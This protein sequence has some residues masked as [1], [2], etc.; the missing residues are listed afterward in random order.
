MATQTNRREFFR[1]IATADTAETR[2]PTTS[3]RNSSLT[4]QQETS[5][6]LAQATLG[7]NLD[8]I[9]TV[10]S[11]GIEAWIDNQFTVPQSEFLNYVNTQ[12]GYDPTS[13]D[14]APAWHF[15]YALGQMMIYGQ[16]LLRQRVALALSEIIVISSESSSI[17]STGNGMAMWFD[18]LLR[19]AFG[20]YRDLLLD[21]TLSPMMGN[22]LS[23]A[24]N[25][26][27][28][29]A[30]NR[31][32]DENYAREL[33]QLFTIGLFLLNDDGSLQLDGN[34]DPI[35]TYDNSDIT[36]FA[37]IFTG[38]D[39]DH[40]GDPRVTWTM[41]FGGGWLNT[42]TAVRPLKYYEDEHESGPKKLLNGTVVADGQ[43]ILQDVNAA[44]DNLFEHQNIAPFISRRLIQS[45]VKS[46]P[47]ADYISRISAVFNNNGA[48]VKG[49][50]QAVIKAILLDDEAR[51]LSFINTTSN[52][53]LREPF[54][55]FTQLMRAFN[56][57]NSET[58]FWDAGWK[59]ENDLRQ[60]PLHAPSVFNFFSP[61]FVPAGPLAA[62]GLRGP[63][64][65]MVNSYTA[66]STINSW[67]AALEW[68][69]VINHPDDVTE[70]AP[71]FSYEESLVTANDI[72][73]LIDHLD[74]LLTYGTLSSAMRDIMR[75]ALQG[76]ADVSW[77]D[78]MDV[79]RFAVHL[80][81]SCP[82]YAVQV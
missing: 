3:V 55:R 80:F 72:D 31:F 47:S 15:R 70:P 19:H 4:S 17:W 79:V 26:K 63:E 56:Y 52:G 57:T 23:H 82:E 16:D 29:L 59:I 30:I 7:A 8:L 18:M 32:P 73:G 44:L 36:E 40:D 46:N 64:F 48:N 71:D 68:D 62:A 22:Y 39:Y 60:Y 28:D 61:D 78:D 50:M 38:M 53:K 20:N 33:K 5:R 14:Q 1:Q 24:G 66:I 77:H 10:N 21:V 45:L 67:H 25:H 13:T 74:L 69:Y 27:T 54:I 49:D 11:M 9:N 42:Y 43:T 6:F 35:P 34:G 81:M 51:N 65:Q 37:K 76:L 58:K 2:A 41:R 75:T 12:T